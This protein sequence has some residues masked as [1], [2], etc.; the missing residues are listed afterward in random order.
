LDIEADGLSH[1]SIVEGLFA[2]LFGRPADESGLST[3][4]QALRAG[5]PLDGM[6][7]ALLKSD[8]FKIQYARM[9]GAGTETSL[10]E[11]LL[12]DLTQLYPDKYT[13]MDS[14]D[15]VFHVG[16]DA[17]FAFMQDLI[18]HHRYY[19]SFGVWQPRVDL[20]KRVTAA[21]VE[22]L[23][24]RNCLEQ[25]CFSGPV[26]GLLQGRGIAVTGVDTHIEG[27][28]AG[29]LG[30]FCQYCRTGEHPCLPAS[31]STPTPCRAGRS[32][33][34]CWRRSANPMTPPSWVMA[35]T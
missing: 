31:S 19:E 7:T 29:S 13:R 5:M 35:G 6:I 18:F 3:Y 25:G 10:P 17:D 28:D 22:G 4:G 12:P 9:I 11:I 23:G 8:E 2:G 33:A 30:L 14:G 24:A 20:D 26:L 16:A 32:P 15:T 21:L 27:G 1:S 34:G